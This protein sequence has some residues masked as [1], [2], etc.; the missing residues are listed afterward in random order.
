VIFDLMGEPA[1]ARSLADPGRDLECNLVSQIRLLEALRRAGRQPLLVISSTRQVYGRPINLPVSEDHPV[2]PPDPNGIHKLAAEQYAFVYGQVYGIPSVVLRIT[3]V[4]G[5]RQGTVDPA[6]GV[7][8]FVIGRL[9]R[10]EPVLLYGGGA[11][12]R[13]WLYVD[14][15][16]DALI[17]AAEAPVAC[18]RVYNIGHDKPASLR[19]FVMAARDFV[20]GGEV[21]EM[22]YPSEQR[23]I[24]VGD[25]WTDPRRAERELR[26]LA[27]TSLA[28][29]LQTTIEFY[30]SRT[31]GERWPP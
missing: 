26:W 30:R 29:G 10:T 14:D 28:D 8:G 16:V 2:A 18:G 19:D 27:G 15:A 7:T 23:V 25:Y 24:D 17:A 21:Q 11:F 20:G 9:L 5:P 31:G 1:H 13:D 22:P 6:H 4:Y 12:R 3:N